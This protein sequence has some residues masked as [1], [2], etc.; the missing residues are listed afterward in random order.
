MTASEGKKKKR[1]WL[2][3]TLNGLLVL[4]VLTLIIPSWRSTV[5][6]WFTYY[7]LVEVDFDKTESVPFPEEQKNWELINADGELINFAEYEGKPIVIQFWA[8]WCTFCKAQ[9][10]DLKSLR[11]NFDNDIAFIAVTNE[12][13]EVL[14]ASGYQEDYDF[15]FCSQYFPEFFQVKV[16]PTLMIMDKNMNVVFS[17]EGA[18]DVDSDENVA[19]LKGLL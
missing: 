15:L 3:Y 18:G 12:P 10:P 9:F 5:Q 19:F 14:Q 6:S 1:K 7:S 4:I 17:M 11:E 2:N 8:T 13:L 16:Y